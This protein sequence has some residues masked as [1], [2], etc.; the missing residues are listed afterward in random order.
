[1]VGL[2]PTRSKEQG[3]LSPLCLPFHHISVFG[4]WCAKLGLNQR[5]R[6]YEFPALTTELLARKEIRKNLR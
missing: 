5:P 4:K 6:N 2:E 3:I 1:M